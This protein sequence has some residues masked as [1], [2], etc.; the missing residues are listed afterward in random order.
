MAALWLTQHLT[1]MSTR[2]ISWGVKA[3][4]ALVQQPYH[5]HV[6]VVLKFRSLN[7]LESSG[8]VQARTG[9]AL[10]LLL[11]LSFEFRE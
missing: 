7:L 10:P 1:E 11:P 4:A 5:L 2:N 3:A 8:S 6:P 9:I